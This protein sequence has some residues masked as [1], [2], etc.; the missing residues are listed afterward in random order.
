MILWFV[1]LVLLVGSFIQRISINVCFCL[2]SLLIKPLFLVCWWCTP[3]VSTGYVEIIELL[4]IQPL[5][6]VGISPN[7]DIAQ[8]SL[9]VGQ[10]PLILVAFK[11]CKFTWAS[12]KPWF[13]VKWST[14]T[15]ALEIPRLSYCW[16]IPYVSLFKS[17]FSLVESFF[18]AI[19]PSFWSLAL[20]SQILLGHIPIYNGI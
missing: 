11:P 14:F 9:L 19:S 3:H 4:V 13:S 5:F 7:V 20:I 15:A 18:L 10:A 12:R 17:P 16:L 6:P 8:L 2:G 1:W